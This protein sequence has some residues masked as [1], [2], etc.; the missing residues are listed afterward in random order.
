M[1][2]FME[3]GISGI[4]EVSRNLAAISGFDSV[5]R[6]KI[7]TEVLAE[8]GKILVLRLREATPRGVTGN[9]ADSTDFQIIISRDTE[10]NDTIYS[11]II[12]QDATAG[13]FVYRPIVVSG[14][15]PGRMPPPLALRGWVELKWGLSGVAA[16]K[17]AFRLA[18]HIAAFGTN[19][20]KY[21]EEVVVASARDVQNAANDLGQHLS[22]EIMD[23]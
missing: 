5:L 18:R 16:D 22:I 11:L 4:T 19:A 10:T 23:F 21:V 9:L 13:S 12:T 6:N 8:L 2:I 3:I 20:N 7:Y 14:R 17:G 1:P 15:N